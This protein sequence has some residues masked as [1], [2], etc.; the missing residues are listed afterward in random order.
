M[1]EREV[2]DAIGDA[3]RITDGVRLDDDDPRLGRPRIDADLVRGRVGWTLV[4]LA[5]VG[6]LVVGLSPAPYVIEQPGPVF[7]TLGEVTTADGQVPMIEI[8]GAE[9]YPTDG[10]L[11]LLTV[12]V[13]GDR[14]NR[15]DWFEIARAWFDPSRAVIPI[16]EVYPEGVTDAEVD[17]Q[18]T[19]L[20][21]DSQQSA[22]AAALGLAGYDY[23]SSANVAEVLE[24]APADGV[25]EVGDVILAIDGAP[26]ALPEQVSD[27]VV[28]AGVGTEMRVRIEREGTERT[29]TVTPAENEGTPRIGIAVGG[30]FEFPID[31]SIQL[32]NVGGPSAG[33]MFA[34]GIYDKLTEGSLTGGVHVAGTGTI[35]AEGDIGAIGGIRQKMYGAQRAGATFFLAPVENCAEVVGNIPDGLQVVTVDTLDDSLAAL[36]ALRDGTAQDLPGCAT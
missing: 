12:S 16:D 8:D 15:P 23:S 11:D 6:T 18:N 24:G 14:S 34:L 32:D 3:E 7:D 25:L 10:R 33:Q 31:V 13:V 27:A 29:V 36:E 28:A 5:L 22:I 21:D 35:D 1:N 17:E 9:S 4:G 2:D 19:V 20:M 26:I 30:S